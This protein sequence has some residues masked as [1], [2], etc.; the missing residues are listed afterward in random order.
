MQPTAAP[1]EHVTRPPAAGLAW[2]DGL[3]LLA[4]AAALVLCLRG[5]GLPALWL[6]LALVPPA[7]LLGLS[8]SYRRL[9]R[10]RFRSLWE[11]VRAY[12]EQGG[13]GVWA[14]TFFFVVIP[15]AFVFLSNGKTVGWG[16]SWPVVPTACSLV[17]EG[18]ADL[19]E[20]LDGSVAWACP[21]PGALPYFATRRGDHA[22]SSY[23]AGMVPFALP[24]VGAARLAGADLDSPRVRERLEKWT[25]AWLAAA[26]L[27]LFFLIALHLA[28][29]PA[30]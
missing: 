27:G 26:S 29:P 28:A 30:A 2:P 25:A 11:A 14:A 16:D 10:D 23:P 19:D 5:R 7:A 9:V 18:N 20:Y 17:R 13:P 8:G 21:R 3:N 12:P 15:A 6:A 24:V 4:A 22:Y 1:P